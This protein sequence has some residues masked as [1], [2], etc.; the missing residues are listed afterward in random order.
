MRDLKWPGLYPQL[1]LWLLVWPA[2]VCVIVSLEKIRAQFMK[3]QSLLSALHLIRVFVYV[4][5]DSIDIVSF[6][7]LKAVIL[8]CSRR[9]NYPLWFTECYFSRWQNED[10]RG[11]E[12]EPPPPTQRAS[13]RAGAGPRDPCL[14]GEGPWQ[15]CVSLD[16]GGWR[17]RC[18][19]RRWGEQVPRPVRQLR[20]GEHLQ[21]HAQGLPGAVRPPGRQAHR[22]QD[23]LS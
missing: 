5:L 15:P 13:S 17:W 3:R 23:L 14:R 2:T 18:S 1:L 10:A 4:G 21:G 16:H 6:K 11:W 20:P 7:H 9:L 12:L 22:V 8:F 19:W